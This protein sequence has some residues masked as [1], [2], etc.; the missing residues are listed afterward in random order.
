MVVSLKLGIFV[1]HLIVKPG[2]AIL[3]EKPVFG[4]VDARYQRVGDRELH[5]A[6]CPVLSGDVLNDSGHPLGKRA[7]VFLESKELYR[8]CIPPIENINHTVIQMSEGSAYKLACSLG[9]SMVL[10]TSW[11]G[12]EMSGYYDNIEPYI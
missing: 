8:T 4:V 2:R 7:V 6:M 1:K 9:M 10:V 12:S 5:I 11:N 3:T